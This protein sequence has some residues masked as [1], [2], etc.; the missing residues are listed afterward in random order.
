MGAVVRSDSQIFRKEESMISFR[1]VKVSDYNRICSFPRDEDELFFLFP[2]GSY[3]LTPNQ[4]NQSIEKR[5]DST[6]IELHGEVAGFANFI[7]AVKSDHCNIG[8]VI[9]NPSLRGKGLGAALINEMCRIAREKYRVKTV[10]IS[11][12][13]ENCTGLLLYTKLGFTPCKV[14][15][16]EKKDGSV[17]ALI[18]LEQ[19]EVI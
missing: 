12:F 10:K 8:N 5:S 11:C 17:T 7:T 1:D 19:C 2:N 16:W 14:T 3:P 6:V 18:H 15:K 13:N 4:L 9:L